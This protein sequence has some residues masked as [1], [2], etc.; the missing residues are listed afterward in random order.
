MMMIRAES[1]AIDGTKKTA[2]LFHPRSRN[3][4][5]FSGSTWDWDSTEHG[6]SKRRQKGFHRTYL[7]ASR[8]LSVVY[9]I[10]GRHSWADLVLIFAV[11]QLSGCGSKYGTAIQPRSLQ[12][13]RGLWNF[14]NHIWR[15]LRYSQDCF[16]ASFARS[17]WPTS[18]SSTAC[19]MRLTSHYGGSTEGISATPFRLYRCCS[20]RIFA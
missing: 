13:R 4:I 10:K 9:L 18:A 16:Q 12:L 3:D 2:V 17:Q 1:K 6:E 19:A 5:I 20:S 8:L 7:I 14:T 11:A 15:G